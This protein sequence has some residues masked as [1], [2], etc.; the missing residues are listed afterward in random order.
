MIACRKPKLLP[1][2]RIPPLPSFHPSGRMRIMRPPPQ[3]IMKS[4]IHLAC[5]VF[6]FATMSNVSSA[7]VLLSENFDGYANQAAFESAWGAIGTTSPMSATLATD[8]AVSG[9]KSIRVDGTATSSQQRIPSSPT[10]GRSG[11][12][13]YN[14]RPG[15]LFQLLFSFERI[16]AINHCCALAYRKETIHVLHS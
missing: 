15:D 14:S 3:T 7:A 1:L 6:A 11:G 5:M 13:F 8:R 10:P 4:S 16:S 2:G 9:T 12:C